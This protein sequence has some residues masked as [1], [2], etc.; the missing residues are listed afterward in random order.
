MKK[1]LF[2]NLVLL[3]LSFQ[4]EARIRK[5]SMKE[6]E[7]MTAGK[8]FLNQVD[9]VCLYL[10]TERIFYVPKLKDNMRLEVTVTFLDEVDRDFV[11][12]H[13]R[14]FQ[15]TLKERLEFY[16]PELAKEFDEQKD[17]AFTVQTGAEKRVLGRFE[18]GAWTWIG[19][20]APR[21]KK[22]EE[23]LSDCKRKCPALIGGEKGESGQRTTDNGQQTEK[24]GDP[25][26]VPEKPAT[27][28][29]RKKIQGEDFPL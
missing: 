8:L 24:K 9:T 19:E 2:L 29:E 18:E 25:E 7:T 3:L 15:K 27:E 12:R 16:T 5:E 26:K 10:S 17:I 21:V 6:S 1:I 11:Q 22:A 4:A 14:T 28:K 23:S 13:A 20:E